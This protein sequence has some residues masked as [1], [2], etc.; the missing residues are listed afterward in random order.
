MKNKVQCSLKPNS[1]SILRAEVKEPVPVVEAEEPQVLCEE[2][3][4]PGEEED[5]AVAVGGAGGQLEVALDL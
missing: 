4:C 2:C 5:S 3:Q 1:F